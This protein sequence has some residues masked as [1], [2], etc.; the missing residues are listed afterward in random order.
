MPEVPAVASENPVMAR[1]LFALLLATLL[2]ACGEGRV[3]APGAGGE[4]LGD[5]S[6]KTG[7]PLGDASQCATPTAPVYRFRRAGAPYLM[8]A[9]EAT[10]ARMQGDAAASFEGEI[11][12]QVVCGQPGLP[13][14][15][16][17]DRHTQAEFYTADPLERDRTRRD[18]TELR[19]DGVAFYVPAG[20]LPGTVPVYRL[21]RA[22][23]YVF[24]TSAAERDR[25]DFV[26]GWNLDGV[27][28]HAYPAQTAP[29][30]CPAGQYWD[31]TRRQCT[32]LC[33]LATDVYVP[34]VGCQTRRAC[35]GGTL[36]AETNTCRCD[37]GLIDNPATD[38]CVPPPC[39]WGEVFVTGKG[40]QVATVC[41]G[42]TVNDRNECTC[43]INYRVIDTSEGFKSCQYDIGFFTDSG[44]G[45][46]GGGG[47][48]GDGGAGL[49]AVK[50]ALVEFWG[51]IEHKMV[52]LGTAIS[53][54]VNGLVHFRKGDYDGPAWVRYLGRDGASYYD[55]A[56][57]RDVAFP[58]GAEL[59]ALVGRLDRSV[60]VTPLTEAAYRYARMHYRSPGETE[61]QKIELILENGYY[62]RANELVRN[63]FN[64][65]MPGSAA[66][67]SE[68]TQFP[69][70]ITAQT[71]ADSLPNDE[72][73]RYAV[74]MAATTYAAKSFNEQ[75][76]RSN[77][78]S[79][80]VGA[81]ALE[82]SRQL[83]SD[84]SDGNLDSRVDGRALAP[85]EE[86]TYTTRSLD[87]SQL[88]M[89]SNFLMSNTLGAGVRDAATEYASPSLEES[90]SPSNE[91]PPTGPPNAPTNACL[92]SN[93]PL[94][95]SNGQG[96]LCCP[97]SL[98]SPDG[99]WGSGCP[100]GGRTDYRRLYLYLRVP[101]VYG[102]A[103]DSWTKGSVAASI[104]AMQPAGAPKSANLG[105][106]ATYLTQVNSLGGTAYLWWTYID[107]PSSTA[108]YYDS[109]SSVELLSVSERLPPLP[110]DP[111]IWL[112]S[113]VSFDPCPAPLRIY[114]IP[115]DAP[116]TGAGGGTGVVP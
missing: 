76:R 3:G 90:L 79:G 96:P 113:P 19:Y 103:L 2:V 10:R 115:I 61:P 15:R 58:P 65:N 43:P 72:S 27:A 110:G 14:Y 49:G 25:F 74:Q 75:L 78:M 39:Q 33:P 31:E 104:L 80:V 38:R 111:L 11:F 12:R 84:L 29:Q 46:G 93:P 81:P 36:I 17:T 73:G 42:G 16:F 85:T 95:Y 52:L 87:L 86:R 105:C 9:D 1:A 100:L 62:N 82:F 34:G 57:G 89:P 30:S 41:L 107:L 59:N 94:F 66:V 23:D 13:L 83:A 68:I 56:L 102:G 106:A 22:G 54:P 37:G 35:T 50:S 26:E 8:V 109:E 48:G 32:P 91:A 99:T 112:R 60:G 51:V 21:S 6:L 45:D 5:A 44:P 4:G 7:V 88:N 97:V 101:G 77:S 69:R 67:I 70:P 53:D 64:A 108:F 18:R 114:T 71:P 47:G 24:T 40:C 116:L 28:F 92:G 20:R 98:T 55:E 63:A